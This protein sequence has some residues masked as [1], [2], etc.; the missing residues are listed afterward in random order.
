MLFLDVGWNEI[1][2]TLVL[3]TVALSW[4][5]I[6]ESLV[7]KEKLSMELSR[8]SI[9]IG[10]GV[11][12]LMCWPI[13]S[14]LCR[15]CRY[16]AASV[17]FTVVIKFIFIACG[18]LS[19]PLTVKMLCRKGNEKQLLLG[20]LM[21]G[22]VIIF[23]TIYYWIEY[24]EG[25]II[26]IILCVGDGTAA[27]GGK[28]LPLMKLPWNNQKSLGGVLSFIISST[29]ILILF[30]EWFSILQYPISSFVTEEYYIPKIIFIICSS[31]FI[32][33]FELGAFDNIIVPC[34]SLLLC[35]F[36]L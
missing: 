1:A 27:I 24:P 19:D 3:F 11:L 34:F 28:V 29:I 14:P 23:A 17:P 22:I 8:K 21:Y 7:K 6:I 18:L 12:Y 33:S 16:L 15:D 10:I 30:L 31:S 5:K 2:Q 9:H 36:I 26:I 32:E 35:K 20:P 25:I 4:T 13:Y